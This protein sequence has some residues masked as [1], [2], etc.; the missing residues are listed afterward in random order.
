[1]FSCF[2]WPK[3]VAGDV[4]RCFVIN[5]MVKS[6][7]E[8]K[9]LFFIAL[10]KVDLVGAKC[11]QE[12]MRLNLLLFLSVCKMTLSAC[13]CCLG[14]ETSGDCVGCRKGLSHK[15]SP[16]LLHVP[17]RI[18]LLFFSVIRSYFVSLIVK[19]SS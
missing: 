15:P 14:S 16:I 11:V 13:L 9:K 8:V 7:H 4:I 3:I 18:S 12:G 1:M 2:T 6:G 19:L 5:S 10:I 17:L